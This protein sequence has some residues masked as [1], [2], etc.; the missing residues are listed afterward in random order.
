[1]QELIKETNAQAEAAAVFQI[2]NYASIPPVY[3]T[4]TKRYGESVAV[5]TEPKVSRNAPCTC[6]SGVKYKK[7]C[8]IRTKI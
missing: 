2:F 7:C 5:R 6:G 3:I 1:M 4:R 8:L